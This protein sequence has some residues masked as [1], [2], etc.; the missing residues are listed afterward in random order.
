M[1]DIQEVDLEAVMEEGTQGQGGG[2]AVV[3]EELDQAEDRGKQD[4]GGGVLEEREIGRFAIVDQRSTMQA[5]FSAAPEVHDA[6]LHSHHVVEGFSPLYKT[7]II[8][9]LLNPTP[10][11]SAETTPQ[12][13]RLG[14][15][16]LEREQPIAPPDSKHWRL[17]LRSSRRPTRPMRSSLM[18][19]SSQATLPAP[20]PPQPQFQDPLG[21]WQPPTLPP[22]LQV[23]IGPH[24][25]AL[26]IKKLADL[27]KKSGFRWDQRQHPYTP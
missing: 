1:Q 15:R 19:A 10:A 14:R 2:D 18:V 9:P 5:P 26:P 12:F 17:S 16:P 25:L 6:I 8:T 27:E 11:P 22:G 23:G 24:G 21:G 13:S 3:T 20:Q 7:H 4:V